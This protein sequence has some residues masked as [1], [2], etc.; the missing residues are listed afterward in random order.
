MCYITTNYY[1]LAS[2]YDKVSIERIIYVC[3]NNLASGY[4][5]V[6]IE[7]ITYVCTNNL[8]SG[9]DKVSIERIIYVC[10]NNPRLVRQSV[11]C[12]FVATC[13]FTNG[14]LQV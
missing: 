14:Q 3:T 4:D 7:R 1:N 6:S 10:T 13:R 2:G 9:Y 12:L 11:L 5:K 8:A